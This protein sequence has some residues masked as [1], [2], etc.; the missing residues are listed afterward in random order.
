M[1]LNDS[2]RREKVSAGLMALY[3]NYANQ[4]DNI[5][6]LHSVREWRSEKVNVRIDFKG[7]HARWMREEVIAV[8]EERRGGCVPRRKFH[9]GLF[10][11]AF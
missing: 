9:H 8:A 4:I 2:E 1:L 7:I 5:A 11:K 3:A 6:M 10:I